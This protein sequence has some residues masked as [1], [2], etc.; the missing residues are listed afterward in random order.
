MIGGLVFS[1]FLTL[2]LTHAFYV[3][4][5]RLSQKIVRKPQAATALRSGNDYASNKVS[6]KSWGVVGDNVVKNLKLEVARH[7]ETTG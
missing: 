7:V 2:Y 6:L 3:V 1:Q 4:L 5:D